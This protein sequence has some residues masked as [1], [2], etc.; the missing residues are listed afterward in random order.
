V[1]PLS[2]V[3]AL[4]PV[5]TAILVTASLSLLMILS[6]VVVKV[7][8]RIGRRR[9]DARRRRLEPLLQQLLGTGR[10]PRALA[11]ATSA[12]MEMLTLM[13]ID[14]FA[15]L[16]G[17]RRDEFLAQL[18][19]LGLVER[20]VR[21]LS[22]RRLWKRARGAEHLGHYG[23]PE[24]ARHLTP[25]LDDPEE[26][27]RAVA[28]RALS[29]V[30]TAEAA[31]A[32]T[33]NLASPS[34]L[35]SLRMAENLERMGMVAVEPLTRLLDSRH[36][37]ERR[38]QVL[39]ARVVGNLRVAE[40]RPALRRAV[41]SRWNTDLRAQATV[42]LGRIGHP[43]DLPSLIDATKDTSWPVRV[44]AANA[45][46]MVG[47]VSTIPM[48][49]TLCADPAWSVRLS[50]AR[51]LAN[52]GPAGERALMAM[53]DGSD[54]FARDRAAAALEERGVLRRLV[55]D[56]PAPDDRGRA[57]EAAIHAFLQAGV[58]RY[59]TTLA[60]SLP[61]GDQLRAL[62]KVMAENRGR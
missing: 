20:D 53:L 44:Q 46:G 43:A 11:R 56:L 54:R 21:Q 32:L 19:G 40:A 7:S 22:S 42:A 51:A 18:R 1:Q 26:T 13:A 61:E 59:L 14:I 33:R 3:Q 28:A 39:A 16:E 55:Q 45:L 36:D 47:D 58:D 2:A 50:A 62:T 12:D 15:V 48:L 57:A 27:V 10:V 60:D 5:V 38:G 41:A 37:H 25:L 31:L 34:E 30:G 23:G 4:T 24:A 35:T 9:A 49:E 29:R 6:T 17:S 8:R 52:M